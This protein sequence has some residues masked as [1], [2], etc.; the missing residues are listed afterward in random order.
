MVRN[1]STQH[2]L[3]Y[4]ILSGKSDCNFFIVLKSFSKSSHSTEGSLQNLE[5]L[6]HWYPDREYITA[7]GS[8]TNNK[9]FKFFNRKSCTSSE[10]TFNPTLVV[11]M[12]WTGNIEQKL[13]KNSSLRHQVF[14]PY[15]RQYGHKCLLW[16]IISWLLINSSLWLSKIKIFYQ[17]IIRALKSKKV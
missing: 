2:Y 17:V 16:I 15:F 3:R 4:M 6:H 5:S 11:F 14:Q 13:S 12:S 1:S 8:L 9:I 10:I 7:L